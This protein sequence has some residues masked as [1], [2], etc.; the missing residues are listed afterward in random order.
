MSLEATIQENTATMKELIA[1]LQASSKA[2]VK[3]SGKKPEATKAE[4]AQSAAAPASTPAARDA[5]TSTSTEVSLDTLK[6]HF[7]K[8]A[9]KKREDAVKV[10]SHFKVARLTELKAEHYAEALKLIEKALA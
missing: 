6:A 4:T 2:T 7:L 5:E 8:L 10:L 3:E 1:A 9:G